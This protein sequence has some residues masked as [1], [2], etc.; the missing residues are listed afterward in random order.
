MCRK[1]HGLLWAMSV[2]DS[3]QTGAIC[4]FPETVPGILLLPWSFCRGRLKGLEMALAL[5][6]TLA[7]L[8]WAE[9]T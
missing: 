4:S 3:R 5:E 1:V 7:S 2:K 6:L 8:E 9:G